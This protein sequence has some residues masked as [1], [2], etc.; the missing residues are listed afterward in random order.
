VY[1]AGPLVAGVAFGVVVDAWLGMCDLRRDFTP[2]PGTLGTRDGTGAAAGLLVLP[3]AGPAP[4]GGG[5]RLPG[6][7]PAGRAVQAVARRSPT[8][9]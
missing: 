1:L 8:G 3:D 9:H 6:L 2:E 4:E 5:A 7:R